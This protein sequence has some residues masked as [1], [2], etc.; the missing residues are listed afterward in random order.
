M[1][2]YDYIVNLPPEKL[3]KVLNHKACIQEHLNDKQESYSPCEVQQIRWLLS[4]KF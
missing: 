4:K 3:Y 1:T 2:N